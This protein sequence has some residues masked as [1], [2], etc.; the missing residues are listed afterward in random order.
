MV[1]QLLNNRNL[2]DSGLSAAT[3]VTFLLQA[4]QCRGLHVTIAR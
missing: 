3:D 4:R 1:M 2:K